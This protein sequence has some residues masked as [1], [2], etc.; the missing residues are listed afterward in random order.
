MT[1][2]ALPVAREVVKLRRT[3]SLAAAERRRERLVRSALA[4]DDRRN[5]VYCHFQRRG[6]RLECAFFATRRGEN[7]DNLHLLGETVRDWLRPDVPDYLWCERLSDH[8]VALVLALNG[9][10]A[11]DAIVLDGIERELELALARLPKTSD[12]H[13]V[14]CDDDILGESIRQLADADD[15]EFRATPGSLEQLDPATMPTLVEV[16]KLPEVR[17]R[18]RVLRIIRRT[19]YVLVLAGIGAAVYS[20][21]SQD[22]DFKPPTFRSSESRLMDEYDLL[23]EAPDPGRV[24]MDIHATYRQFLDEFPNWDILWLRWTSKTGLKIAAALPL[25]PT[26]EE[27]VQLSDDEV[28]ETA[29]WIDGRAKA[30]GWN[31]DLSSRNASN[32]RL[33]FEA[34][35][36]TLAGVDRTSDQIAANRR[37]EPARGDPWHRS[38]LVQHLEMLTRVVGIV[39]LKPART[40]SVY[41]EYPLEVELRDVEWARPDTANWL[42]QRFADGPVAL[43]SVVVIPQ[44]PVSLA[45]VQ[46]KFRVAWCTVDTATGNCTTAD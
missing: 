35:W 7:A 31:I 8:S 28:V 13:I 30:L 24:L 1:A 6:G 10:I 14:Y 38:S 3:S 40:T 21:I 15:I 41:R 5:D 19:I 11:K 2:F 12:R 9:R 18:Q 4:M 45:G 32:P 16:E 29:E 39:R 46:V 25:H 37:P 36:P 42:A 44:S 27:I 34:M 17:R 33:K 22:E 26:T 23:L 20:Y 43:S